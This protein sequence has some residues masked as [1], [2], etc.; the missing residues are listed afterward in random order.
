MTVK[1]NYIQITVLIIILAVTVYAGVNYLTGKRTADLQ[2]EIEKKLADQK[3]ILKT[4]SEV[5]GRNGAD[6]TTEAIV[7]DCSVEERKEFDNLL[8]KLDEGLPQSELQKLDRLFGR[9]GYYF[10]QRK[11]IMVARLNREVMVYE[12][13]VSQLEALTGSSKSDEYAIETWK[14]LAENENKQSVLFMDLVRTQ[15]SIISTLLSGK[16]ADS[17]E[18]QV[19]LNEVKEIQGTLSVTNIQTA[20]LRTEL[21]AK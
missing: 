15:D 16:T 3:A 19:I 21:L 17:S 13:F 11:S 6:A 8:G 1:L 7:S 5:T 12:N 18:M 14:K 4:I 20:D 10:A 9:C 2:I